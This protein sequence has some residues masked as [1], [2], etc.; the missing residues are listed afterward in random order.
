MKHPKDIEELPLCIFLIE[1]ENKKLQYLDCHGEPQLKD[2]TPENINIKDMLNIKFSEL[3]DKRKKPKCN[4]VLGSKQIYFD[5]KKLKAKIAEKEEEL[6][7][8][9]FE[10]EPRDIMLSERENYLLVNYQ[11]EKGADVYKFY[12][13][14]KGHVDRNGLILYRFP[15]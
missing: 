7:D 12:D 13:S 5:K 10:H 2:F 4:R 15:D 1:F 8:V 9:E 11:F 6:F 3:D 14:K